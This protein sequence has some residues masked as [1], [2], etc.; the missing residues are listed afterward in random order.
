MIEVLMFLFDN[1]LSLEES[2]YDD[3][4]LAVELEE[5][6]FQ[7]KEI[8]KAFD[9]LG[10][11]TSLFKEEPNFLKVPGESTRVYCAQ[12]QQKLDVAC[13][14]FLLSLEQ[15]GLLDALTR[16]IIIEQVMIIEELRLN[17][18]QFK[19][20]VGLVILNK[21]QGEEVLLWLEEILYD[22]KEVPH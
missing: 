16:E 8:G 22:L 20:I 15:L 11:L 18:Q 3:A 6:G 1:Y 17:L 13:Q 14:G 21:M 10:K 5:A 7:I 4:T 2:S 12:E 19:R 9:W